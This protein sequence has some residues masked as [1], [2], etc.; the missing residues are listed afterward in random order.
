MPFFGGTI[1]FIRGTYICYV[2]GWDYIQR[3]LF[4]RGLNYVNHKVI[5]LPPFK[6]K[7][8]FILGS[9]LQN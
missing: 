6:Q 5:I 3:G 9:T 4:L 1:F 7:P 2:C 8:F